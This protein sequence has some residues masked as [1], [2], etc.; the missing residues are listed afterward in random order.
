MLFV[1][2]RKFGSF[3]LETLYFIYFALGTLIAKSGLEEKAFSNNI[4]TAISF[5]A[6]LLMTDFWVSG[7]TSV[8]N[9]II[10]IVVS[11]S[12]IVITYLSCT[13]L[14]WN[15]KFDNF[16]IQCGQ[17]SL[18]IYVMHWMFLRIWTEIDIPQNELLAFLPVLLYGVVICYVCIL[19]KKIL[20]LS[21]LMDFVLFG[22]KIRRK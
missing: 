17:F 21:P 7:Q 4:V 2:W 22:N 3:K 6:V 14:N 19:L 15:V 20:A 18:A 11:C 10:K 12:V 8:L 9:I 13:R 16:I 1:V 5:V